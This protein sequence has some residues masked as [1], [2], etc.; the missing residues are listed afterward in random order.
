MTDAMP[1]T[2]L[3]PGDRVPMSW[4]EYQAL[5]CDVPGEYIDG[6]LVMSPS[7]TGRH[8][9]L[10]ASLWSV[11]KN[12]L[13]PQV[14]IRQGWAWKPADDEFIP[15]LMVFDDT[16]EQVRYTGTPHLVV[17]VL[18]DDRG[19]D[20]LRKFAK[21]AQAGCPRYWVV[22]PEGPLIVA[23]ELRQG[24]YTETGRYQGDQSVTLPLGPADIT[25]TPAQLTG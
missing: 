7:R 21:H 13:P 22:D 15:D 18:S 25:L 11:S 20:L 1:L 16:D 12:Q 4:E 8:Q 19:R 14:R 2:D 9:D 3:A 6:E 23:Y 17:E 5:G 24:V 10:V